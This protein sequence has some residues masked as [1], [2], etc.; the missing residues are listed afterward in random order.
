MRRLW[1]TIA[2]VVVLGGLF[3]YIYFV[4]W[5]KPDTDAASKQE[6]VFASIQAD[7]IDEI[8]ITS[9][10][11]DVT[12]LKKDK[13]GWQIVAPGSARAD[14]SELSGITSNLVSVEMTRVIDENPTDLKDYGLATPRVEVD[15]KVEGGKDYRRLLIGEKSPT[16]ADLFAKRDTEK[17][18]F[19]IPVLQESTFN[20]STFD[21]RDKTLLKFDRDKVDGIEVI[22]GG[23][24]VQL[25]KDGSDWKI[26]KPIQGRADFGS[27]EGLIGRVQSVQMKSIVTDEARPADLKK[28]GLDK[29]DV[30]LHVGAG[31]A[32]ATLLVGGKADNNMLYARDASR[33]AVMTID[34]S[35]ADELKKGADVYR[36]MEIF[37]L[38][39]FTTSR[40]E[41]TRDGRT[42]V[43]EKAKASAD[44]APESWRR[45]SPTAGDVD[46]D[47]MA[48]FLSKLEGIRAQ[49]FVDSTTKTGLASPALT[50]VAKFDDGKKEER[51]AFGKTADGVYAARQGEP[52]AAKIDTGDF[53][54]VNGKLNEL[55]K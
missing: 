21:L 3:A 27:V 39:S 43:F 48:A 30:T 40:L 14:E 13:A 38:R 51:V 23:K 46:K 35:L 19:L 10:K 45:V 18:V 11:G 52:G 7:K 47:K 31:S 50:V 42:V 54:D 24:S 2:L 20:R 29:P 22:A 26:A 34:S 15:F 37:E 12:G 6:K 55:S 17:R 5:K 41:L 1:S 9:D 25:A 28:Y 53:T 49:S 36:R 8:R 44:K 33:P 32:K 4:L 16:G